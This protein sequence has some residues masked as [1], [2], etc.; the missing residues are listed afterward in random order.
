[1]PDKYQNLEDQ[2]GGP[3]DEAFGSAVFRRSVAAGH[4]LESEARDVYHDFVGELW[5][6]WGAATWLGP[7]KQLAARDSKQ[8]GSIL[9]LL[10]AISDPGARSAADQLLEG[11]EHAVTASTTLMEAFDHD[12]ISELKVFEIGDGDA[13]SG[14]IIAGYD[15]DLMEDIFLIFLMD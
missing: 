5:E 12:A 9:S 1:M 15:A 8:G 10:Q 11:G 2:F 14:L 7:W 3:S 13:M 6:R 4:D